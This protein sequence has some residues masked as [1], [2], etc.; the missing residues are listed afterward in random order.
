MSAVVDPQTLGAVKSAQPQAADSQQVLLDWPQHRSPLTIWQRRLPTALS[1]AAA[2][3]AKRQ[4]PYEH[5]LTW[6]PTEPLPDLSPALNALNPAA[7]EA[8]RSWIA[9]D[10]LGL[11]QLAG[12]L[13]QSLSG[14]LS[15]DQLAIRLERVTGDGCRLFHVDRLVARLICTWTGPGTEWLPEGSFDRSGLGCGCNDH[16]LDFDARRQLLCGD[17]AL[18]RGDLCR[19]F[20]GKGL[21]HRSPPGVAGKARLLIAIDLR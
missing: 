11:I 17:V 8:D 4:A 13:A 1:A 9:D 18:L 3:F 15:T 7:S 20:E 19:G 10:C 21:V 16:V 5:R 12:Q 2:L 14:E 6:S